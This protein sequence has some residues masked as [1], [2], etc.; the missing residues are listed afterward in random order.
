MNRNHAP[1]NFRGITAFGLSG[2]Y[3][4]FLF[5]RFACSDEIFALTVSRR[6]PGSAPSPPTPLALLG[7]ALSALPAGHPVQAQ[8]AR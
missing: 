3:F 1:N 8:L 4:I 5:P 6:I 7:Y 2:L